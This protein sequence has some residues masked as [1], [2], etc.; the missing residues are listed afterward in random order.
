MWG[1]YQAQPFKRA[2]ELR[3]RFRVRLRIRDGASGRESIA[4]NTNAN[5]KTKTRAVVKLASSART[6]RA[7]AARSAVPDPCSRARVRRQRPSRHLRCVR[8]PPAAD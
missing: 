4:A 8:A 3:R 2:P 1:V 6:E 7:G 5:T